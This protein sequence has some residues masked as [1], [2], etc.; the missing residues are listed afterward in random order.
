M[1]VDVTLRVVGL[2]SVDQ[3]RR[4]SFGNGKFVVP[5]DVLSRGYPR[6]ALCFGHIGLSYIPLLFY[7]YDRIWSHCDRLGSSLSWSGRL[8][9]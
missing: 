8:V 6:I 7:G 4:A 1:C 5:V 9:A 3:V 2:M